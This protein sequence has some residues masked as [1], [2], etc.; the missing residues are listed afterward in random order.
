M[1]RPTAAQ[2]P[3]AVATIEF[4]RSGTART[5][6]SVIHHRPM[7]PGLIGMSWRTALPDWVVFVSAGRANVVLRAERD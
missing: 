6:K 4:D 5:G 3:N 2:Q 1:S 7:R